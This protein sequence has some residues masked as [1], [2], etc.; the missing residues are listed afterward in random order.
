LSQL[1]RVDP[2]E[3]PVGR[4]GQYRSGK[5]YWLGASDGGLF[6]FG[7]AGFYGSAGSTHLNKPVVG[8]VQS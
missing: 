2:P 5:G 3:G 7:D 8:M 4:H 6:N 1:A